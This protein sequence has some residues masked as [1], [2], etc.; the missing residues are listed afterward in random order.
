MASGIRMLLAGL[1]LIANTIVIMLFALAGGAVF[2]PIY[3]WYS[4]NAKAGGAIP[5]NLVQWF[6]GM[7]FG[8]LILLEI[9][10]IYVTYQAAFVS[11]QY[12]QEY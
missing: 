5:T 6:P 9:I 12:S 7:F 3:A 4:I 1:S 8:L 2:G 11:S 10:L